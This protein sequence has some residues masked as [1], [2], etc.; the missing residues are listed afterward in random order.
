MR[1]EAGCRS[2][3]R[4]GVDPGKHVALDQ[5][6]QQA[7]R[8]DDVIPVNVQRAIVILE[9]NKMPD[10]AERESWHDIGEHSETKAHHV[11]L[12]LSLS[13]R[14][15]SAETPSTK[16]RRQPPCACSFISAASCS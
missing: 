1:S 9:Q 5:H 16:V 14:C 12:F 8:D 10:E 11:S 13:S 3:E 2:V 4:S 6:R 15:L 7:E